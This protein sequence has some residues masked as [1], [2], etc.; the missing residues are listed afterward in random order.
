MADYSKYVDKYGD[1]SSVWKKIE[2]GSGDQYDY[3][4]KKGLQIR[5]LLVRYTSQRAEALKDVL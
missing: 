3:W 1:L 5:R 2:S 4:S